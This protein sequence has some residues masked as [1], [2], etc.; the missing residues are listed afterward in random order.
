MH[1]ACMQRAMTK[2]RLYRRA[3]NDI[4]KPLAH[5]QPT[6]DSLKTMIAKCGNQQRLIA[7]VERIR[8]IV[9]TELCIRVHLLVIVSSVILLLVVIAKI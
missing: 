9:R 6:Q 7:C 2:L 3:P 8:P 4:P 1:M 5:A